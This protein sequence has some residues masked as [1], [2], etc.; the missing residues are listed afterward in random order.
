[1]A[2]DVGVPLLELHTA[3]LDDPRYR[4]NDGERCYWCKSQLFAHAAAAAEERGWSLAYGE[5]ADDDPADRPGARSAAERGVVSPLRAAGWNKA[6]VRAYAS[7]VG[8]VVADKPAAPCLASRIA[9]GVAVQLEDL[10][11]I[12]A[13]EGRLKERGYRVLRARHLGARRLALEFAATELARAEAEQALLVDLAAEFG[14][15]DCRLRIYTSG[16]VA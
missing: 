1:V 5:N 10:E 15:H 6:A 4:A 2:A 7:A 9:T 14:Y 3:E 13:L 12:E 11:R 8:L 16:S